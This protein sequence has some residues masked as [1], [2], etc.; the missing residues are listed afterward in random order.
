M[1]YH[2]MNEINKKIIMIDLRK[3]FLEMNKDF[4]VDYIY[5]KVFCFLIKIDVA[6]DD[7]KGSQVVEVALDAINTVLHW[8]AT[9]L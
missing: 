6:I 5:D 2:M 9:T 8:V 3:S 1:A 4:I 7:A